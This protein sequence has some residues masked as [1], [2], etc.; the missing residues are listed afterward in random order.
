MEP[1]ARH[2]MSFG[3][4]HGAQAFNG[5]FLAQGGVPRVARLVQQKLVEHRVAKREFAREV[6]VEGTLGDA[7]AVQD[8]AQRR[9]LKADPV[10]FVGRRLENFL[11]GDFGFEFALCDHELSLQTGRSVFKVDA[12]NF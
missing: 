1:H 7:E 10:D 5:I 2:Y 9:G 4:K 8:V 11:A 12:K 6:V 3:L